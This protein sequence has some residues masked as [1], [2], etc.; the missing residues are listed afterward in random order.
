MI[1]LF[2]LFKTIQSGTISTYN[3]LFPL[4]PKINLYTHILA[5]NIIIDMKKIA[6]KN[7]DTI[8]PFPWPKSAPGETPLCTVQQV[9]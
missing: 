5:S 8:P 2:Y 1:K 7:I 3:I 6:W 4:A 9:Q